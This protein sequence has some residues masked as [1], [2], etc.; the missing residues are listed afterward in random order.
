MK[1]LA[2]TIRHWVSIGLC[3]LG[4][5]VMPILNSYYNRKDVELNISFH[6]LEPYL[7]YQWLPFTVFFL[8]GAAYALPDPRWRLFAWIIFILGMLI[9]GV[10]W[11]YAALNS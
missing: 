1:I 8:L 5:V 4:L 10:S 3:V 6:F 11:L 2:F 7:W 9:S